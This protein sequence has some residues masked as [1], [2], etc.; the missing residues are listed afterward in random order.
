LIIIVLQYGTQE[1]E[2]LQERNE[3][4]NE[5]IQ[6]RTPEPEEGEERK[7]FGK[8]FNKIEG[9][10]TRYRQQGDLKRKEKEAERAEVQARIAEIKEQKRGELRQARIN[11]RVAQVQEKYNKKLD[12]QKKTPGQRFNIISSKAKKIGGKFNTYFGDTSSKLGGL[13]PNI[14]RDP[15]QNFFNA[16]K[17]NSLIGNTPKKKTTKKATDS[18]E[19]YEERVKTSA[20]Q[21]SVIQQRA[22]SL[23]SQVYQ[24]AECLQEAAK[25][26]DD[27]PV[28]LKRLERIRQSCLTFVRTVEHQ[29]PNQA[30]CSYVMPQENERE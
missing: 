27:N 26:A 1:E 7:T 21:V 25:K 11:Q 20:E 15:T 28:V 18:N 16:D 12:W 6:E 24:F 4:L 3:Q 13:S 9:A 17:I 8:F 30:H 5:E 23:F 2:E 29:M 22:R 14:G 19:F 10:Y